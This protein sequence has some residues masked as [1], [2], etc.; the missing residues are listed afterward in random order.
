MK[1][2]S[3]DWHLG[4]NSILVVG[5]RPFK[6]VEEMGEA[7]LENTTSLTKKGDILYMLGDV[8]WKTDAALP[9]LRGL[10]KHGLD[11][12][13]IEG[14]HDHRLNATSKKMYF[15]QVYN[16]LH[17]LHEGSVRVSLSHFPMVSWDRSF[18]DNWQLYGHLHTKSQEMPFVEDI[19]KGKA[20]NVNV[21]FNNYKPW[22][23]D[24]VEAYMSS[25]PSN[26]DTD[27]FRTNYLEESE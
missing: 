7:L 14:N 10:K 15:N 18:A 19:L 9:I 1:W 27:I 5:Q 3:S 8:C 21:E 16:G 25:R 11:L 4:H 12:R 17:V 20:L 26:R 2:F 6:T 22:S 13:L 23:W 24:E